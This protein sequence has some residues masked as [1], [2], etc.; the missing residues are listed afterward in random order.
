MPELG[1]PTKPP[2]MSPGPPAI[3]TSPPQ[4]RVPINLPTPARLKYHGIASP[5]EPARSLMII[6]FGPKIPCGCIRGSP[7]RFDAALSSFRLRISAMSVAS[8]P[9]P[10]KR[11]STMAASFPIC[12]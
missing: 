3:P 2:S 9:P 7:T 11:S 8:R 4:V 12:A 1:A 5:P 10:L 6:T